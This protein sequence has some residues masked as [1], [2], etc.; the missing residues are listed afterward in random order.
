MS[1]KDLSPFKNLK[2]DLPASIVVFLVALPLC[3]GIAQVSEAPPLAGI[4]AGIL[5]GVLVGSLSGSPLGVS[6]P[7]AG[8]AV[9]VANSI[10]DLGGFE[11]FLV[12]V[13]LAGV[14]QVIM[15]FAKAG[16]I[17]Y[18]FPTSVIHGMLAG[19]GLKIFFKQIPHAFGYDKDP[20]GNEEFLN[21]NGQTDLEVLYNLGDF[22]DTNILMITTV[23]ISILLIW[24]TKFIKKQS[25]SKIIPGPFLAVL[26]GILFSLYFSRDT[27]TA[28]QS[29]HLVNLPSFDSMTDFDSN[30]TLPNFSVL[31]NPKIY[32][33][34]LIIAAVASIET[35]LCVEAADKQDDYKRITPTNKE[36]KAQGIGNIVAGF[37]GGLPITQVI[38]RSSANHQ[39]GG[40]T[41]M[42]TILHGIFL[43]ASV[44]AIPSILNL[45]PLATLAAILL[46][47]GYKLAKPALFKKMYK[48]GMGQF[49]PFIVTIVVMMFSDLLIGVGSGLIVAIFI[50]LRNNFKVALEVTKK[51]TDEKQI[52]TIKLSEDV[53]FLNK[54]SIL[55]TLSRVPDNNILTIDATNTYYIHY[56]VKE[57]L[58]DFKISAVNRNIE[59]VFI[60]ENENKQQ[61]PLEHFKVINN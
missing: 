3:L 34:A 32:I 42:S 25:F 31:T 49:L 46:V 8:L 1:T 44:I 37:V 12:A 61:E 18:Y 29:D 39:S 60:D 52:F 53:T 21:A 35:L 45:I 51:D 11:N 30:I 54:A 43:F 27:G 20:E 2:N 17:A 13:I 47:V 26:A 59:V 16:I 33:T 40:M 14:I 55:K 10:A 6:G 7:A 57:I 28:L 19:I 36:L 24:E 48:E 15:G 56:D 22:I 58:E 9:I 23:C 50:I 41:K 5:G 38:V 4:I